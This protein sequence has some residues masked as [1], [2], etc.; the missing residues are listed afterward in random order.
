MACGVSPCQLAGTACS[1]SNQNLAVGLIL[2]AGLWLCG[3]ACGSE[4]A[5]RLAL[6]AYMLH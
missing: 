3:R 5:C 1:P 4:T 2:P 6:S